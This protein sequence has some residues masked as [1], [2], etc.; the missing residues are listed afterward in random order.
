MKKWK[1]NAYEWKSKSY[2]LS[3]GK[4]VHQQQMQ[5]CQ[6]GN[7]CVHN[8]CST[9]NFCLQNWRR[10]LVTSLFTFKTILK[11]SNDFHYMYFH[12][13]L[14]GIQT[15][16]DGWSRPSRWAGSPIASIFIYSRQM[17]HIFCIILNQLLMQYSQNNHY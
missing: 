7:L 13:L 3:D 6:K 12:D 11:F 16:L 15:S 14:A 4:F 10:T 5:Y 2:T 17:H 1:L 9:N 8:R